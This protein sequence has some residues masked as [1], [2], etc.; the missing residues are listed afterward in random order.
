M[1]PNLDCSWVPGLSDISAVIQQITTPRAPLCWQPPCVG[2]ID[3]STGLSLPFWVLELVWRSRV[4]LREWCQARQKRAR[5]DGALPTWGHLA[6]LSPSC[7]AAEVIPDQLGLPEIPVLVHLPSPEL[8]HQNPR[9]SAALG[10]PTM[11][12]SP[13]RTSP[14]ASRADVMSPCAPLTPR[15][16]VWPQQVGNTEWLNTTGGS[17]GGSLTHKGGVQQSQPVAG[18]RAEELARSVH[19]T[20]PKSGAPCTAS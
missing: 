8:S 17:M 16:P 7:E 6:D 13:L 15:H 20:P 5:A 12:A 10:I 11:G 2:S 1:S 3:A 9:T 18:G 4:A 19:L 14:D